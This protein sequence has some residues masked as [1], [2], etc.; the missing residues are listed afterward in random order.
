[1]SS[2]LSL[3]FPSIICFYIQT[4]IYFIQV[5]SCRQ[6]V[7]EGIFFLSYDFAVVVTSNTYRNSQSMVNTSAEAQHCGRASVGSDHSFAV[8]LQI[9]SFKT[10]LGA[11]VVQLCLL[12][13]L[14]QI[15]ALSSSREWFA[16][17]L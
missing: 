12:P 4:Y 1:M 5:L 3:C 9:E 13:L 16:S 10:N 8:A 17:F 2:V 14:P 15:L 7:T 6:Q 11:E